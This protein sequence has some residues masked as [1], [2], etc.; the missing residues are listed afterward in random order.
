MA[1]LIRRGLWPHINRLSQ[2]ESVPTFSIFHFQF[3][4]DIAS[5]FGFAACERFFRHA[6]G[7]NEKLPPAGSRK[8]ILTR[9]KALKEAFQLKVD[10]GKSKVQ[11]QISPWPI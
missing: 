5:H 10:S 4:I 3:S 6:E 8:R 2:G 9:D 7:G 1:D 11:E